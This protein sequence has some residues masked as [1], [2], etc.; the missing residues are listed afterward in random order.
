MYVNA[1][2]AFD[3]GVDAPPGGEVPV[4]GAAMALGPK[5]TKRLKVYG[6]K[7]GQKG[8]AASSSKSVVQPASE[9][10]LSKLALLQKRCRRTV[11]GRML[12]LQ[13]KSSRRL[14]LPRR[15]RR[16]PIASC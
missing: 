2:E 15:C 14:T 16:Q 11:G 8:G 13:L 5:G 10:A 7:R 9:P 1:D 12:L 4:G 6:K 3:T